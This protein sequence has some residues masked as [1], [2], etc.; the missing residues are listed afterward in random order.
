MLLLTFG[1][2][3]EQFVQAFIHLCRR[4]EMLGTDGRRV[5]VNTNNA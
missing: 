3:Q 1:N 5:A 4:A 2:V